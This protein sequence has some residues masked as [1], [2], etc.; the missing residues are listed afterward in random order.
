[1]AAQFV[2]HAFGAVQESLKNAYNYLANVVRMQ[3]IHQQ[4]AH[5]WEA[6]K[7]GLTREARGLRVEIGRLRDELAI[8]ER[9]L[10]MR[11]E[12]VDALELNVQD[13]QQQVRRQQAVNDN[14]VNGIQEA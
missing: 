4:R 1:M 13:L 12:T 8:S 14:Q 5:Q 7:A 2:Q 10:N 11:N 3:H 6:A 9:V